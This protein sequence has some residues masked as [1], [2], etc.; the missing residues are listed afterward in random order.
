MLVGLAG[1]G[2][3][4]GGAASGSPGY[5][6]RQPVLYQVRGRLHHAP[7]PAGWA[8]AAAL[9]AE[10]HQVFVQA[11]RASGPY[12][13]LFEPT[14][15]QLALDTRACTNAGTGTPCSRAYAKN[16][17]AWCWTIP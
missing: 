9:A 1:H 4:E 12:E 2:A 13:A 3:V 10:H 5:G 11:A 14:A 6:A 15:P 8:L 17:G 16:R 7:R